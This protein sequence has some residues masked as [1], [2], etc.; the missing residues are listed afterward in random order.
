MITILSPA[1]TLDFEKGRQVKKHTLPDFRDEAKGLVEN[2]RQYSVDELMDLMN[3]SRDI[4]ELNYQRFI[5]FSDHY[6]KENARQAVL[7]FRGEVYRGLDADSLSEKSLDYAQDHLRILSGMYGVLKPLDYLQAYRLEMGTSLDN[8]KGKDLYVFWGD[9]IT[10]N[11][12][13]VLKKQKE[14]VLVN[15][16]S[17]EYF[18]AVKPK[19]IEGRIVTPVFKESKG[20]SYRVIAVYAKKARGLMTRFII[21][22]SIEQPDDLKAFDLEG[23][24]YNEQLSKEEE[25]VFTR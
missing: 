21:Q 18:K 8:N 22:N 25:L 3:V 7:A 9:K 20:D 4:A 14:K 11:L 24:M 19:K 10:E 15:L 5:G 1:K 13:N 23:Y 2:L 6:T 17:K 12:N 16:A